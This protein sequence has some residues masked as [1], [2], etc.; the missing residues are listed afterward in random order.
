MFNYQLQ[1]NHYSDDTIIY[2]Y[3]PLDCMESGEL[4]VNKNH[5]ITEWLISFRKAGYSPERARKSRNGELTSL[6]K[7]YLSPEIVEESEQSK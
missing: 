2:I 3:E 5:K 1:C 4:N 6:E 7:K